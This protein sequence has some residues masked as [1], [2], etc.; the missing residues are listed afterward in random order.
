MQILPWIAAVSTFALFAAALGA[1]R[2][3]ARRPA[4]AVPL[5]NEWRLTGR[6]VFS[7]D[8]R[9]V[10]RQLR[11]ALPQHVVLAKLPLVRFCQPVDPEQRRF[12]Y[13]LL[14][15]I[16]I[17]FVICS[18]EG[19]LLLAIDLDADR[20]TSQCVLQ[21]KRAVLDACKVRY[22]RCPI[23]ALPAGVDLQRMVPGSA[24]ARSVVAPQAREADLDVARDA[25]ASTV[26]LRRAE[27]TVRWQDS[28]QFQDSFFVTDGAGEGFGDSQFASAAPVAV[29]HVFAH[30][31]ATDADDDPGRGVVDTSASAAKLDQGLPDALGPPRAG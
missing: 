31:N 9:I 11:E 17:G 23:E 19:R 12:W 2:S 6:P 29:A 27:R 25:L 21:I 30:C 14:G 15:Q 26:A 1:W 4:T 8:E 7:A 13:E 22:L 24:I 16:H 10:H 28:A 20:H 3:W 5:P 18:A